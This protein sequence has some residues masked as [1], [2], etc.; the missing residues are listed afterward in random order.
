LLACLVL[1][2]DSSS[3]QRWQNAGRFESIR[4]ANVT[5]QNL[6]KSVDLVSYWGSVKQMIVDT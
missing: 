6:T 2:I 1:L 3:S 4:I 5:C